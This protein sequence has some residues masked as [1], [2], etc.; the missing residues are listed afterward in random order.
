QAS[1][2]LYARG[3]A[4]NTSAIESAPS[5]KSAIVRK[6]ITSQRQKICPS[7]AKFFLFGSLFRA[8]IISTAMALA[9]QTKSALPRS[10][11]RRSELVSRFAIAV[12]AHFLGNETAV[13][14]SLAGGA[15]ENH[16][17]ACSG[18]ASSR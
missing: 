1:P 2:G 12:V 6:R 13:T 16:V 5:S 4:R 11:S 8:A 10:L 15:M 17:R 18:V 14:F 7:T 3:L 9:V